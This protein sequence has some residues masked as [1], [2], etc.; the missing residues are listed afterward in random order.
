MVYVCSFS[1][2]FAMQSD[3]WTF[4]TQKQ[5]WISHSEMFC[6]SQNIF[7]HKKFGEHSEDREWK[8]TLIKNYE[9][10]ELVM[11][12]KSHAPNC[13]RRQIAADRDRRAAVDS[14]PK[15]PVA[16]CFF[17]AAR[18]F[19]KKS[20]SRFISIRRIGSQWNWV[21]Q[22]SRWSITAHY[23]T[24]NHAGQIKSLITVHS[25]G[26]SSEWRWIRYGGLTS[27]WWSYRSISFDLWCCMCVCLVLIETNCY[28]SEGEW[29]VVQGI[30]CCWLWR[31][32]RWLRRRSTVRVIWEKH[33]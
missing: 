4:F 12:R 17:I 16:L 7:P 33:I 2:T 18:S 25:V 10:F 28:C 23:P 26:K 27:W 24:E 11:M 31:R 5:E 32:R 19:C 14:I 1:V 8:I 22:R 3:C 15:S 13:G 6:V 21:S 9:L 20:V 30:I 29:S